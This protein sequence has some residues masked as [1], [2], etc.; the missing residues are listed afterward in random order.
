MPCSK[1]DYVAVARVIS[2]AAFINCATQSEVNMNSDTRKKIANQ[3]A[4][5]FQGNIPRFD[6]A[7][8]LT[9]CGITMHPSFNGITD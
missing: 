9:A 2:D 8:F 6:R 1:K 7:R 3:I 5:Y 4:D